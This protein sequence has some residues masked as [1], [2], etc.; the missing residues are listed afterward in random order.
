MQGSKKEQIN[1]KI[2]KLAEKHRG[3]IDGWE[4]KNYILTFLFYRYISENITYAI[5]EKMRISKPDFDFL[6]I[7]D[8]EAQKLDKNRL[9]SAK[10]FY[11]KPSN[12]FSRFLDRIRNN[13]ENSDN[14]I[15]TKDT[16]INKKD[17]NV[18]LEKVFR[19]IEEHSEIEGHKP[20][21][22]LL[23]NIQLNNTI[24]GQDTVSRNERIFDML[25]DIKS[26]DLGDFNENTIKSDLF[27]DAY[28]YLISMYSSAA[29]KSGGEFFTPQEVSTLLT[30][31]TLTY[32]NKLKI[33]TIYDPTCGSGSLLLKFAKQININDIRIYGQ[34]INPTTY[35]L[36]K[37]NMFLHGV[38]YDK[39]DIQ[40]GDT[41]LNP[42]H[43]TQK[44]DIIVSNPPYSRKDWQKGKDFSSD[45]RFK[46]VGI[47]PPDSNADFAFL[48]HIYHQLE[49]T[50]VAAVVCFAS[51]ASRGRVEKNIRKF[52]I[53]QSIEAVIQLPSNI[54]FGTGIETIIL[55]MRKT[56]QNDKIL[57]INASQ[58]FVKDKINGKKKNKLSSKNID[59]ILDVVKN[60]KEIEN[61]S[62]IVSLQEI[63]DND[64]DL[65]PS[66]YTKV[67]KEELIDIKQ[68]DS[69][70]KE[71]N[72]KNIEL[73]KIIDNF[74]LNIED[75][76]LDNEDEL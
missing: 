52:L 32:H 59:D 27:G 46:E 26:F 41:L 62:K 56:K 44:F 34:E 2:W 15:N 49:T 4:F 74:L 29:G 55:V 20:L 3:S 6:K 40:H 21:A 60:N 39:F 36:C 38:A 76:D 68:I 54:F 63:E 37:V 8:E 69:Q 53:Q 65:A 51:I 47:V 50:G 7:S 73:Q 43:K 30:Q 42:K 57:L 14:R 19:E 75:I 61:V 9:I 16:I 18:E 23:R 67:E 58:M 64:W 48:L 35:T 28:E 25:Q 12:L 66:K 72:L 22:G 70:I 24:I 13:N 17:L 71:L 31:I 1:E 45:E 11:I 5:N 33:K 10:G